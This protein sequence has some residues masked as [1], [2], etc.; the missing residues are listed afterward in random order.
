MIWGFEITDRSLG[1]LKIKE[2]KSGCPFK[3]VV[4]TNISKSLTDAKRIHVKA[5]VRQKKKKKSTNKGV[6][7]FLETPRVV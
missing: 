1:L 6:S 7:A 4:P 5:T 2:R 3:F